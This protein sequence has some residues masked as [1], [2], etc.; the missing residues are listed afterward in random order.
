MLTGRRAFPGDNQMSTLAAILQQEPKALA[1]LD[2]RIP[3]EM[4]RIVMRCLRKDPDRRFQHMADLKVALEELKEESDSGKLTPPTG[5]RGQTAANLAAPAGRALVVLVAAVGGLALVEFQAGEN[6][7][8]ADHP[9]DFNRRCDFSRYLSGREVAGLSVIHRR[10]R[11]GHLDPANRRRAMASRSRT[12]KAAPCFPCFSP[13]G[14]EIAYE[15]HDNIYEVPAL[16]GAPRLIA[17]D[18]FEPL[19]TRDGSAIVFVRSMHGRA[20]LIKAPRAGGTEADIDP[21]LRFRSLPVISPDGSRLLA[22]GSRA[23]RPNDVAHW[24]TIPIAGGN[25]EEMAAP[26]LLPGE[27]QVPAPLAWMAAEKDSRQ[28]V[29]FGRPDG[30]TYNLFRVPATNGSSDAG[31]GAAHFHYGALLQSPRFRHRADGVLQ[32]NRDHESLEYSDRYQPRAGHGDRQALTQGEGVLNDS[33]TLSRD[34]KHAGL[35]LRQSP[36]GER[37]HHRPRNAIGA[38]S[39][40]QPRD[41]FLHFSGWHRGCVLR[42]RSNSDRGGPLCRLDR[43]RSVAPGLPGLWESGRFLIRWQACANGDGTS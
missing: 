12:K 42:P 22:A 35:F 16:G 17:S 30:D 37:P 5:P 31:A 20:H 27:V 34:G 24:W 29:I 13:D 3:R 1:D 26:A 40:H 7:A 28:W 10:A 43:R 18:G 39:A 32:R 6:R 21:E 36:N 2:P 41:A 11:S 19:Y 9:A 38:R 14:T 25:K 4:E 23:D 15:S 33:P 8:A